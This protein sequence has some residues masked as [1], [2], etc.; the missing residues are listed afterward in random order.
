MI[1]PPPRPPPIVVREPRR[2]V[3]MRFIA[4]NNT[5]TAQAAKK[6]LDKRSF[7]RRSS[8][9]F[10]VAGLALV[11]VPILFGRF[12]AGNYKPL[13][14]LGFGGSLLSVLPDWMAGSLLMVFGLSLVVRLNVGK[15]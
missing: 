8:Y 6:R 10:N 4:H 5:R 13:I 3:G 11:A 9:R 7:I 2:V 1:S 14:A 12:A 15:K